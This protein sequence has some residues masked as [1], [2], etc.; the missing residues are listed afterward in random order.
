MDS[1]ISLLGDEKQKVLDE[2]AKHK[3]DLLDL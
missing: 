1:Q 2:I 3:R